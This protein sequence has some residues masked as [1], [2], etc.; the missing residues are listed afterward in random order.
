HREN[1][2]EN[3][4]S[5]I[6]LFTLGIVIYTS[7]FYIMNNKYKPIW[8]S[9][10]PPL[11]YSM[12]ALYKGCVDQY[13]TSQR[14]K[15]VVTREKSGK[16]ALLRSCYN[17]ENLTA[18][19]V[20]CNIH[21]YTAQNL[22]K[23]S[24]AVVKSEDQATSTRLSIAIVGDS[25]SRQFFVSLAHLLKDTNL[26]YY[27]QGKSGNIR[28]FISVLFAEPFH[29][30]IRLVSN[31]APLTITFYWDPFLTTSLPKLLK[32]WL[33]D[34]ATR[35]HLLHIGTGVHYLERAKEEV[36]DSFEKNWRNLLLALSA[37]SNTTH[38]IVKMTDHVL[39]FWEII[40]PLSADLYQ[41]QNPL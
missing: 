30:T 19:N 41:E 38:T 32:Q 24:A 17:Y 25:R 31:D 33:A 28:D 20:C 4:K 36:F 27:C 10:L 14:V 29:N 15:S 5:Y 26:T 34:P 6:L 11:N 16:N 8:D 35:P 37:L 13:N 39:G 3:Y 21:N 23:C 12:C 40:Y 1:T 9:Y 7:C 22:T 18:I 2:M